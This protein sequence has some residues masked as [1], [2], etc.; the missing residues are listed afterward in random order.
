MKPSEL[1]LPDN[2]ANTNSISWTPLRLSLCPSLLP[3]TESCLLTLPQ[4]IQKPILL[5][6]LLAMHLLAPAIMVT[7]CPVLLMKE[8]R[9]ARP[10]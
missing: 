4:P 6:H 1:Y 10:F 7:R 8:K 9:D 5:F 3:L 2:C